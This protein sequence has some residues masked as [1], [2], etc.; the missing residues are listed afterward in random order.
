M[1]FDGQYLTY[2]E[3]KNLGGTLDITPFNLLEFEA[4]RKINSK[5]QNRLIGVDD[6]P[7]E[8]KICDFHLINSICKY[9]ND[10]VSLSSVSNGNVASETIDGYSVTY[11]S[12]DK[13]TE[14]IKSKNI[15]LDNIIRDDLLGV[16][17]NE[18]HILY[19]GF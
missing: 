16:I 2:T 7:Q 1:N 19:R 3:Y 8:V 9:V 13:M 10:D 14:V 17:V 12:K 18:Q 4:R 11:I 15:E 5:T 6:I